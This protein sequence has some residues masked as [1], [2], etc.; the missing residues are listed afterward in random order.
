[1]EKY[2]FSGNIGA[3]S[4]IESLLQISETDFGNDASANNIMHD[5]QFEIP[6]SEIMMDGFCQE[7]ENSSENNRIREPQ[8]SAFSAYI[9]PQLNARVADSSGVS[10]ENLHKRCLR[11]LRENDQDRKVGVQRSHR[12]APAVA[13][14]NNEELKEKK[15]DK[16]KS[17][18]Q[19]M[20]AERNRRVKLNQHFQN[21]YYLLPRNC[22]KDKHSILANATY[23]L[24][25]LKLRV[26]ELQQRSES[27]DELIPRNFSNSS[28]EVSVRFESHDNPFNSG[29]LLLYRSDDVIL[30]QCDDIP[31]EV[32]IKINVETKMVS[33]SASLL[34][35]VIELLR[36][37]QLE[38]LSVSHKKG[39][40]FQ[41]TFVVLPKG[42]DWDISHWQ[43]FGSL[44]S[45]TLSG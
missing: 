2:D 12:T 24:K 33:C 9:K 6:I 43:T 25:E 8:H 19:H 13:R 17:A 37:W 1:M 5:A 38:I 34:L 30:E 27:V 4:A 14:N 23:Y 36:A 20:I 18:F 28:E 39:S 21:L 42:E 40:G 29:S 45:R 32:K 15:K 26:C 22:K 11:F 31:C 7:L 44:V 35:R 3:C 10:S 16:A 41:A